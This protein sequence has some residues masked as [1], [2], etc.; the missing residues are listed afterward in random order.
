MDNLGFSKTKFPS[1]IKK[2]KDLKLLATA[3]RNNILTTI[4]NS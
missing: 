2:F 3:Q 1:K 4:S